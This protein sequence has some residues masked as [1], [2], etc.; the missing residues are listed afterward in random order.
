MGATSTVR[1]IENHYPSQRSPEC[2]TSV[3]GSGGISVAPRRSWVWAG[4]GAI[5]AVAWVGILVGQVFIR[6]GTIVGILVDHLFQNPTHA[7]R[8]Q[9][10]IVWEVRVPRV[11][12]G[13]VVGAALAVSGVV[14]QAV[15]RNPL[16]DSYVIGVTPGA[17]L[18]AVVAIVLG[19]GAGSLGVAGAAF[20]GALL[21]FA[22]IVLLARRA[23]GW[24]P[25]RVILA[26]VAIGYLLSA[27]TFFLQ[28][29]ATPAQLQRTLFWSLGSVAGV[30]WSQLPVLVA[31]TVAGCAWLLVRS[32]WLD[33]LASG[34]ELARSQGI[35][36][37]RFQIELMAIAALITACV[38]AIV[39][40]IG[41][42]GLVI[43]H[44]ARF[45]VGTVHRRV[46]VASLLF[47]AS[48]LPAADIVARTALAPSELPIGIITAAVGAPLFIAQLTRADRAVS[49]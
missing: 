7:T 8:V 31:V 45:V 25:G 36:V 33:A 12:A 26:G 9:E 19:I 47:G 3:A 24:A 28:I 17:T 15:V 42:V 13:I 38:V 6:P 37:D 48:F 11:L 2:A 14:I 20:V 29:R 46:L 40:G 21:A 35:P 39:G 1:A 49:R 16:G 10:Q 43:P 5:I 30:G 32:R 44:V 23:G 22:G 41:F 27:A 4:L 34:P 18:G